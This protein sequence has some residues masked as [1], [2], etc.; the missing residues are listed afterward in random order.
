MRRGRHGPHPAGRP[1]PSPCP[2]SGHFPLQSLLPRRNSSA[3]PG[4][5]AVGGCAPPVRVVRAPRLQAPSTT[6]SARPCRLPPPVHSPPPQTAGLRP[7][8]GVAS[9][10]PRPPPTRP[11]FKSSLRLLRWFLF[12]FPTRCLHSGSCASFYL[13]YVKCR[14]Q[15]HKVCPKRFSILEIYVKMYM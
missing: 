1:S 3:T 5:D 7:S 11:P 9:A 10:P 14:S 8:L 12:A 4:S 6:A 15:I 13:T 2:P